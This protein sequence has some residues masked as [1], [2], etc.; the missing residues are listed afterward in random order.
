MGKIL[1][2]PVSTE[3]SGLLRQEHTGAETWL[4]LVAVDGQFFVD[5]RAVIMKCAM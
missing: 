5:F 3:K 1:F 4:R 2:Y